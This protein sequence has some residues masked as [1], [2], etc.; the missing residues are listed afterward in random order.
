MMRRTPK[1]ELDS[2]ISNL[3]SRLAADG[4]DGA[5]IVQNAD[6]LYFAGT[7]QQSFLYVPS[8]VRGMSR[9]SIM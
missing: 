7:V 4:V 1:E 6:L 2:R 3:Q 8:R 5:L 9:L